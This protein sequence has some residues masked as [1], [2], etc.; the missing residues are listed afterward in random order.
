M[1]RV[2]AARGAVDDALVHARAAVAIR[3][4]TDAPT[5]QADTYRALA[6][7]LSAAGRADES[8]AALDEARRRYEMKG[9]L[10][11]LAAIDRELALSSP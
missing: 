11:S 2:L 6:A 5:L 4:Q 1:A 8:S 10:V 7:V 3:A 9:D